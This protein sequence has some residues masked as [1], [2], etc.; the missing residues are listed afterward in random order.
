M[1]SV[2][3]MFKFEKPSKTAYKNTQWRETIRMQ[4]LW[5]MFKFEKPSK[6]SKTAY[7]NT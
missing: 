3:K 2:W 5:K 6:T 1:Q 7:K 4:T